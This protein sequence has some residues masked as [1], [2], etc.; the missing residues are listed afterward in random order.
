MKKNFR[1]F[2]GS[3][4]KAAKFAHALQTLLERERD[5][6]ISIRARVWDQGL[7]P[8]GSITANEL[9]RR[10]GEYDFAVF[11]FAPDDLIT[12]GSKTY[13]VARD[14]VVFEL[15]LFMGRLGRE[16]VFYIVPRDQQDFHIPSD[17]HGVTWAA[18]DSAAAREELLSALQAASDQI[19]A[20]ITSLGNVTSRP[21]ADERFDELVSKIDRLLSES[22][23]KAI[24][25]FPGFLESHICPLLESGGAIW[26][27]CDVLH[28]G[29]FSAPKI[30]RRYRE[31][32][33]DE[34]KILVVNA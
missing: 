14:N 30:C 22:Q 27:L 32:F 16:R 9:L 10:A 6:E 23:T 13:F 7:L 12:A 31:A 28:Y 20:K 29:M 25:H 2:L 8:L 11:V 21:S 5:D 33:T 3:S 24:G 4:S 26:I 15:G 19:Y 34:T 18:F 1:L 17:L